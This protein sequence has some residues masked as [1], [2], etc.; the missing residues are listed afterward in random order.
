[1][2]LNRTRRRQR[3]VL[4]YG[5]LRRDWYNSNQTLPRLI[6]QIA[7]GRRR[8]VFIGFPR[9]WIPVFEWFGVPWEKSTSPANYI[10]F[11][12][13]FSEN[14][15]VKIV[16]R[17]RR[18]GTLRILVESA[19]MYDAVVSD[20]L[21]IVDNTVRTESASMQNDLL[22]ATNRCAAKRRPLLLN[23][24]Q[25]YGRPSLRLLESWA[26]AV[27][28]QSSIAV[29]LPCAL[30]RPYDRSQTH[31]K[32]YRILEDQGHPLKTLHRVVITS[33]GILPEEVWSMPQ[34]IA[35]NAGVPDI[36]R[37]LR[38]GRAFFGMAKYSLVID[39]LQ[40]EPYS[41]VLNILRMEGVIRKLERIRVQGKRQFFLRSW[42]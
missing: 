1:M 16:H 5:S 27:K 38:L 31:K 17:S 13:D 21:Y 14:R 20:L 34:V 33:L 8:C 7:E 36:Y 26:L 19:S 25:S 28:P 42:I 24:W 18:E 39:C 23:G 12:S 22:E 37:I 35:Y 40:F 2:S 4:E 15:L 3:E 29:A 32:I 11:F 30:A 10:P 9:Q 41:D 6:R